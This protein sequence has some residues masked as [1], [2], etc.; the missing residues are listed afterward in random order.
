MLCYLLQNAIK[1]PREVLKTTVG[2]GLKDAVESCILKILHR[3]SWNPSQL[4][5]LTRALPQ[6]RA[7]APRPVKQLVR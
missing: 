4:F 2:L 7:E 5:A 6:Y 3:F 1:N